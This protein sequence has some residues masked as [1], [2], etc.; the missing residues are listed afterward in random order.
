MDNGADQA[1][2]SHHDLDYLTIVITLVAAL[3]ERTG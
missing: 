2:Y 3:I 1:S